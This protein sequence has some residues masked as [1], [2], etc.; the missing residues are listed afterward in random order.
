MI[1]NDTYVILGLF[2]RIGWMFKSRPNLGTFGSSITVKNEQNKLRREILDNDV[3]P[4]THRVGPP[5]T[6]LIDLSKGSDNEKIKDEAI[7]EE[8]KKEEPQKEEPKKDDNTNLNK[9][10]LS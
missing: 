5:K 6:E 4:W 7:K 8:P 10:E 9:M 3:L 2:S 1:F